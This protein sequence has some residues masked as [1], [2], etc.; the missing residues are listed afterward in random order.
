M[1]NCP[2]YKISDLSVLNTLDE[3]YSLFRSTILANTFYSIFV[4]YKE[5]I[6]EDL[7]F[8][9]LVLTPNDYDNYYD[10]P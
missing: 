3:S 10:Y 9:A 6:I 1:K 4:Q 7:I 8:R 5:K 2:Y